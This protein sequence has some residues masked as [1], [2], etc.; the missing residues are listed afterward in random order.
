MVKVVYFSPT[1]T[2]KAVVEAIASKI[3]ADFSAYDITLE[4]QRGDGLTFNDEDIVI[5]GA[6][7]YSGRIPSLVEDFLKKTEKSKALFVPVVVYGNRAYEDAL[8][9]LK[10]IFVNKGFEMVAGAA[11]IGEHSFTDEVAKG[12]PRVDDLS[13]AGTF[14]LSIKEKVALIRQ[15]ASESEK[16][17]VEV[18][19]N[20]LYRE[21]KASLPLGPKT[22]DACIDCKV[23][24]N[25]CP[26]S[27]ITFDDCNEVDEEK[28]IRCFSCVKKCP[29]QAKYFDEKFDGTI[30]WV[31]ENCQSPRKEPELFI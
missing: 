5:V 13:V 28:C 14:G 9:E 6:P 1:G 29:T 12:R 20:K 7:V 15:D 10:D 31:I 22:T 8:L 19:G 4:K 11:F 25:S 24:S 18:K 21:R 3:D 17:D 30:A 2:T 23:C 26:V 27:A 16:V